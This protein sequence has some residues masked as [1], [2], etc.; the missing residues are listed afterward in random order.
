[1]NL[2]HE[3]IRFRRTFFC[4]IGCAGYPPFSA[5][6][7]SRRSGRVPGG[8]GE[9][10]R[11]TGLLG[12]RLGDPPRRHLHAR[13]RRL[14]RRVPAAAGP[15]GAEGAQAGQQRINLEL[16][17]GLGP[18]RSCTSL[19][20]LELG[21]KQLTGGLEP[22]R[23]CTALAALELEGNQLTG[24]LEPLQGCV[25]LQCL[26]LSDNELTGGLEPLRG[27][28]KAGGASPPEEQVDWRPRAPQRLI[29]RHCSG[30]TAE[31]IN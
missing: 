19:Q 26:A 2:L 29:A 22:L 14:H 7:L 24:S 23:G 9:Q 8:D 13:R 11:T 28:K 17:G 10:L 20:W 6:A 12:Q 15:H 18:L 31:T 25:A 21:H 1:V 16:T 27:C 4:Y 5:V 30:S 3:C